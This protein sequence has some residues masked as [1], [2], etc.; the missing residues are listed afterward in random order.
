MHLKFNAFYLQKD[1]TDEGSSMSLRQDLTYHYLY[2]SIILIIVAITNRR[3][4]EDKTVQSA[5][6]RAQI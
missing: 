5:L 3:K 6:S 4:R 1:E 2:R